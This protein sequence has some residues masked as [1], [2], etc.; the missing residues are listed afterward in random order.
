M[1]NL[2]DINV[3]L[4]TDLTSGVYV[5]EVE[6]NSPADKAGLKSG[7][8]IVKV[9]D[10]DVSSLAF[11]KYQLYKHNVGDKINVSFYRGDDLKVVTIELSKAAS[12]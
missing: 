7:D 1:Y 5:S 6:K 11:L 4:R 9:D 12:E 10:V 8:I 3:P 2:S